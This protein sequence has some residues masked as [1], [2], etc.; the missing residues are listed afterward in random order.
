MALWRGRPIFK[1]SS[2]LFLLTGIASCMSYK[3]NTKMSCSFVRM[4]VWQ[5]WRSAQTCAAESVISY[6]SGS[7]LALPM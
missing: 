3:N 6:E 5:F 2:E 1:Q 4:V 7:A